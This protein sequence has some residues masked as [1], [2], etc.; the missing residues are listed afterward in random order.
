MVTGSSKGR[1]KRPEYEDQE[2]QR[3]ETVVQNQVARVGFYEKVII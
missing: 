3:V 1:R 2:L